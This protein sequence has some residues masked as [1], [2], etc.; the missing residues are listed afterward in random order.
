MNK[1]QYCKK[2]FDDDKVNICQKCLMKIVCMNYR[3]KESFGYD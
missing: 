1:C 3:D 2:E